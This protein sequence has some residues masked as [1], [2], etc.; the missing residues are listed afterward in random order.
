M[1]APAMVAS[2]ACGGEHRGGKGPASTV[3]PKAEN[4]APVCPATGQAPAKLPGVLP[5]ETKLSYWLKQTAKA[6]HDVDAPVLTVAQIRDL[7]ASFAVE[8]DGF[9]P[10]VDLLGEKDPHL[11]L[12]DVEKRRVWLNE[13]FA[14]GEY[15]GAT[16]ARVDPRAAPPSQ[17]EIEPVIRVALGDV[18]FRCAPTDDG[19]FAPTLD[20]S[21]DH[22]QCSTA[23]A[24]EPI[25]IYAHWPEN[26]LLARTRYTWGYIR[27][28]SPLSP[29]LSTADAERFVHGPFATVTANAPIEPGGDAATLSP[30][31]RVPLAGGKSR[32]A[33]A[34]KDGVTTAKVPADTLDPNRRPLT[35]RAVLSAAFRLL[36]TPY[37]YGGNKGGRDC[38][39]VLLD[40]FESFGIAFPRHSS[41]QA[42]AGSYRID[43]TG[44]DETA[45]LRVIDAADDHGIVLLH[46]P[47][48]MMLYL[49][50]DERGRAMALHALA[51]YVVPCEKG[52]G[53][54]IFKVNRVSVTDL[55]LGRDTSRRA[56][57]ERIHDVIVLG[58]PPGEK[59]VG[60]ANLRP[61]A[62]VA[63]PDRRT[64]ARAASD[65]I[66]V[67]PARPT[68][69]S[70]MRIVATQAVAPGSVEL[71][72]FGPDGRQVPPPV[73]TGGPPFGVIATVDKPGAGKWTAV[74]GDGEHIAA[75]KTFRVARRTQPVDTGADDGP[76]WEIR[77]QWSPEVEDLFAVFVERLFDYPPTEDLTWPNLHT[78]LR[79]PARN[80]LYDQ[81]GQNGDDT[82]ELSPDCAD[83][84]YT[85]RAYFAWKLGLP[86]GYHEC[87]R[88]RPGHPPQCQAGASNLI[89]RAEI[90]ATGD[91]SAFDQFIQRGVRQAVHSSSGRTH[92]ADGDTDFYPVPLTREALT[93]GTL[94]VD[95]Y[96]HLMVV[97][98]WVAQGRDGYG[99]LIAADAQPDGTVGRKRFWRG[100]F[101]FIP[102]TKSG[103]AGFKA[104]RPWR[105][106]SD[107]SLVQ[108]NNKQLARRDGAPFSTMQYQGSADDFYDRVNALINPRPL[109]PLAAQ[110]VIVDALEEA[111]VRRIVSVDNS[112]KYLAEHGGAVIPMPP[113]AAIFRTSG[114]WE[115]YSTPSRDWRLLVSIDV[116]LGFPA[117]VRRSPEQFG[118]DPDDAD[119]VAK[120]LSA[121]LAAELAARKFSYTR[122]DGSSWELSLKD[123]VDRRT[124]F[125]MAYNPNDCVE[126]RWAA[127][128]GS[129]E[130]TT[131]KR[132]APDDQ[133]EQMKTAR[134]W[135]AERSRPPT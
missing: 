64:C 108:P 41:W 117:N 22:N 52:D 28:D 65:R 74:L 119:E 75:C 106:A 94:F 101:M 116:T 53:E 18:P 124:A 96:G 135:F 87:G 13:K 84:P 114:P 102:D 79:D 129:E 60:I 4:G 112:E 131:C 130:A 133:R 31:T 43:V 92:P 103:G 122:S 125:E 91:V 104:F 78:L 66:L 110:K 17:P 35:R 23:R 77:Q 51:E 61:P 81:L 99:M 11:I 72:L 123:V 54:T 25:L 97:A 120:K 113:G 59:L 27:A 56:F 63:K 16:G 7:N 19:F 6:G 98:D 134:S 82:L 89:T 40:I 95:P 128:S 10:Q 42:Q 58:S 121:A 100:S 69:A 38:S 83:L 107:G 126:L 50:R 73:T 48:H 34:T 109:D 47:G 2:V 30:G 29:P 37:G 115:D 85:L 111:V 76:A 20:L 5:A 44:M 9:H 55:T 86:F 24:Q 80:I 3:D 12:E 90:G 67:S 57:I 127:P 1:L 45:R 105:V 71:A 8:R 118:V 62:Q 49:G 88:A 132:H 36:G 26:W 14:A 15:L 46:I 32:I 93:P 39:R 70:A 21:I 33:I 68:V